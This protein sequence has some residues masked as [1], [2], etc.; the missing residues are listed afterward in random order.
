VEELLSF[1]SELNV[2]FVSNSF[3]ILH[4]AKSDSWN[5]VARVC[6]LATFLLVF[7]SLGARLLGARA[8]VHTR[9]RLDDFRDYDHYD[10]SAPSISHWIWMQ[11]CWGYGEMLRDYFISPLCVGQSSRF[12]RAGDYSHQWWAELQRDCGDLSACSNRTTLRVAYR[13][14]FDGV[15]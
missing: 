6:S 3:F 2:M 10:W 11:H 5:S 7:R 4:W 15:N 1:A 9:G 14:F 13:R 8:G 12:I